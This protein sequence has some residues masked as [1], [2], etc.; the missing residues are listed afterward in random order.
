MSANKINGNDLFKLHFYNNVFIYRDFSIIIQIPRI[1]SI[2]LTKTD[3]IYII[4]F[5]LRISENIVVFLQAINDDFRV[6]EMLTQ[7]KLHRFQTLFAIHNIVKSYLIIPFGESAENALHRWWVDPKANRC[8][9]AHS[10]LRYHNL[11]ISLR[12][13]SNLRFVAREQEWILYSHATRNINSNTCKTAKSCYVPTTN[14]THAKMHKSR[15][16]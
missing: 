9:K 13:I 4:Y 14:N 7:S 8:K 10:R 15:Q 6:I 2:S 5:F 11:V 16:F 3:I 1:N 12:R